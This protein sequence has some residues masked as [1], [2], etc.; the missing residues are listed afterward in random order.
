MRVSRMWAGGESDRLVTRREINIKP[1]YQR[2]DKVTS[3]AYQGKR[4]A[5]SQICL[6]DGV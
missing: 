5:E 4:S 1:C 3:L 6:G 2:M